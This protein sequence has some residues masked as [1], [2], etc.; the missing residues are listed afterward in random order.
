MKLT[1]PKAAG[2]KDTYTFKEM[3]TVTA[4]ARRLAF[5]EI[6][7]LIDHDRDNGNLET[8][9]PHKGH[10]GFSPAHCLSKIVKLCEAEINK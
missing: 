9:I 5:P 4:E 6:L 8:D 2:A 10:K 3:I 7:S 1:T